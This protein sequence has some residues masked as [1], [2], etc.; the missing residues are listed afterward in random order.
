[1]TRA[2]S[3]WAPVALTMAAIFYTSA[4]PDL[5]LP[6]GLPDKPSHVMAYTPL[7]F[8]LVRA[9]AGGLR[10]PMTVSTVLLR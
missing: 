1:M 4:Q 3:L 9:I 6:P 10:A 8:L 2:L 5:A 7:G